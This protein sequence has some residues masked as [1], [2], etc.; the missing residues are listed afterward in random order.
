MQMPNNSALGA[1][2]NAPNVKLPPISNGATEGTNSNAVNGQT[3][4]GQT[5]GHG[6]TDAHGQ[7]QST[8]KGVHVSAKS[9]QLIYRSIPPKVQNFTLSDML[10]SSVSATMK[11]KKPKGSSLTSSS[12]F[13]KRFMARPVT[14]P[15]VIDFSVG[16]VKMEKRRR[17]INGFFPPVKLRVSAKKEY[18][19]S[20]SSPEVKFCIK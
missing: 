14:Q 4:H 17:G 12:E 1:A 13:A 11:S 20:L 7:T 19:K 9:Q 6:Q 16:K 15:K 10:D 2:N 3:A 8:N 18:Q 5:N